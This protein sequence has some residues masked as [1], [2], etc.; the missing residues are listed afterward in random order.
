MKNTSIFMICRLTSRT[1]LREILLVILTIA[2]VLAGYA[3]PLFGF[4]YIQIVSTQRMSPNTEFSTI[5]YGSWTSSAKKILS[6]SNWFQVVWI[7]TMTYP[8]K[9]VDLI[10][11]WNRANECFIRNAMC[12]FTNAFYAKTC[13]SRIAK[14]RLRPLPAFCFGIE[15]NFLGDALANK[16]PVVSNL[17]H[18]AAILA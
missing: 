11:S 6:W 4:C 17:W 9:M 13:I 16:F 2:S 7:N 5:I 10:P 14:S 15:N 12:T 1:L 3:H 18:G 8:T